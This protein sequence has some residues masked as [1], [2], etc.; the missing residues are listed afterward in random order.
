MEL[1]K[2]SLLAIWI[3]EVAAGGL[4]LI[5]LYRRRLT[6]A[7][8]FVCGYLAFGFLRS[9][10]LL[11]LWIA[12]HYTA[13][14]TIWRATQ[15]LLIAA[16]ALMVLEAI[17]A[18]AS[19][20]PKIG[21]FAGT[22]CGGFTVISAV[23]CLYAANVAIAP[24]FVS[25]VAWLA[26]Y[27]TYLCFSVL[28]FSRLLFWLARPEMRP[29]VRRHLAILLSFFAF[30]GLSATLV[31]T[32]QGKASAPAVIAGQLLTVA[33]PLVCYAA[34]TVCLTK[35]G[36]QFEPMPYRAYTPEELEPDWTLIT[37]LG[38]AARQALRKATAVRA[39]R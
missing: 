16:Y 32:F 31:A 14:S 18:Q 2:A 23:I 26:K 17:F 15:P 37:A 9:S 28:A 30:S 6:G 19:H 10:W 21:W 4:C 36:Q 13:Y 35:A 33:N 24:S 20:F 38:R 25:E 8:P 29:N 3:A 39:V 11:P 22:L 5:A 27:Y 1:F 7:Y 34:W 12:Q